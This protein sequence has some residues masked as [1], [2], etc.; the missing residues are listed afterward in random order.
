[1]PLLQ[2]AKDC[3]KY[4]KILENSWSKHPS[5]HPNKKDEKLSQDAMLISHALCT[6]EGAVC[7]LESGEWPKLQR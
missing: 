4:A 6:K 5:H 3:R 2:E 1:M 7:S